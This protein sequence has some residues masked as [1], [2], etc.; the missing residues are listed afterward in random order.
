MTAINQNTDLVTPS[1]VTFTFSGQITNGTSGIDLSTFSARFVAKP[2][3]LSTAT[4]IDITN[5][6]IVL[7]AE[8][9]VQFTVDNTAMQIAPNKG[10][11]SLVIRNA[12]GQD[13]YFMSG[14]FIVTA[15]GL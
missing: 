1:G 13:E 7:T 14:R 12:S 11:Y 2:F 8:G 4:W 5:P 9:F 10:I 6:Q 3:A 15:T